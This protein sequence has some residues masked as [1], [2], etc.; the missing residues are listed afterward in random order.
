MRISRIMFW[1][2]G[3]AFGMSCVM[4][5]GLGTFFTPQAGTVYLVGLM[6]L[7]TGHLAAAS[8]C[9]S[10]FE[11]KRAQLLMAIGVIASLCGFIL[12]ATYIFGS[13]LSNVIEDWGHIAAT[14][15]SAVAGYAGFAAILYHMPDRN[16]AVS[17]LRRLVLTIAA[18]SATHVIL[19]V[20]GYEFLNLAY[21]QEYE[22]VDRHVRWGAALAIA[23]GYFTMVMIG[24]LYFARLRS[25]D[26]PAVDPLPLRVTCPRCKAAQKLKTE[27][28]SCSECGLRI[29]VSLA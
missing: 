9:I 22:Y 14:P 26:R 18:L 28:D 5:M 11:R 8:V 12:W 4:H 17:W 13:E 25:G 15:A 10:A 24:I 2:L 27:G 3:A 23:V 16:V 20:I 19:A 6:W 1:V 7:F 29:K 21:A